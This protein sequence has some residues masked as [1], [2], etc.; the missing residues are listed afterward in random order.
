MAQRDEPGAAV[1]SAAKHALTAAFEVGDEVLDLFDVVPVPVPGSTGDQWEIWYYPKTTQRIQDLA[2]WND[3]AEK[4]GNYAVIY[5]CDTEEVLD[6]SWSHET[7]WVDQPYAQDTWATAPAY[8]GRLLPWVKALR[9]AT[10]AIAAR[11]PEDASDYD[12]TWE[13]AA[14]YDTYFRQAGFDAQQFSRSMPGKDDIAYEEA[15]AIAMAAILSEMPHAQDAL[16]HADIRAEYSLFDPDTPMWRF[17]CFFQNDGIE[18]NFG[19][20]MDA[21]TGEVL[22]INP[23]VG[24]DG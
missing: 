10:N 22:L 13:D 15:R 3:I 23:V 21:K 8:H 5:D 18:I 12:Y 1:R 19:V 17:S 4:I 20:A 2:V 6:V 11:Y 7:E 9:D 16:A 24:G 14:A